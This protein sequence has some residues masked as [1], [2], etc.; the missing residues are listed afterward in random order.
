MWAR[1]SPRTASPSRAFSVA[2]PGLEHLH[3]PRI[4]EHPPATIDCHPATRGA[5]FVGS[6]GHGENPCRAVR[7][8]PGRTISR[9]DPARRT[10]KPG[11]VCWLDA[12]D[13]LE[14]IV[15]TQA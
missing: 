12:A 11:F 4:V 8:C 2:I 1:F 5:T 7:A 10:I 15:Q 6:G 3:P 9:N 14:S 13:G